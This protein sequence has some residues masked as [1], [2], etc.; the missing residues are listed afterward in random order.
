MAYHWE[1]SQLKA[2]AVEKNQTLAEE[3]GEALAQF[4]AQTMPIIEAE[5]DYEGA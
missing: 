4:R 1:Q 5:E 3:V 2:E